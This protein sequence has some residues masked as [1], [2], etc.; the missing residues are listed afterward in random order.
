M[1]RLWTVAAL[2][3]S[4]W[5]LGGC[6]LVVDFDESLVVDPGFGGEGGD[7]GAAGTG[8]EGGSSGEGGHGGDAGSA[9]PRS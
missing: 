9:G 7:A 6:S 4:S 3:V 8:G 2:V 1:G 5:S